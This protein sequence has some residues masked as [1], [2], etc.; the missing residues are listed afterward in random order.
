MSYEVGE[1]R[2]YHQVD[3]VCGRIIYMVLSVEEATAVILFLFIEH[4][5]DL[6]HVGSTRRY[7]LNDPLF[8][9]SDL[10]ALG[11]EC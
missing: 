10:V 11:T 6:W 4:G 2:E 1:V 7:F 3:D 8:F 5:H 9:M